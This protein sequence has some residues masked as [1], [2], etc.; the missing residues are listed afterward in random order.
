MSQGHIED[1]LSGTFICSVAFNA[2]DTGYFGIRSET[3]TY[4]SELPEPSMICLLGFG[5]LI[6]FKKNK[7]KQKTV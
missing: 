4:F 3:D 7:I 1:T 5:S 2:G 6:L